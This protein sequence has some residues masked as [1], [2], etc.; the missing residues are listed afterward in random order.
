MGETEFLKAHSRQ[1]IS[2][3]GQVRSHNLNSNTMMEVW[4]LLET[5]IVC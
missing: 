5:K 2:D 1:Q 3:V 4:I